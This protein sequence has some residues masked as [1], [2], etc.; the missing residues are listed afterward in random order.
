[1][2]DHM[3]KMR[4][5]L[6]E[7]GDVVHLPMRTPSPVKEIQTVT[8]LVNGLEYIVRL[9]SGVEI[10]CTPGWKFSVERKVA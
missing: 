5:A 10:T 9:A 2:N 7:V 4:A 6:I 8:G 3:D 1:M